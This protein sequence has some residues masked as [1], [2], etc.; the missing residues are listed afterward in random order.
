[1]NTEI[2]LTPTA[3]QF[4]FGQAGR[5]ITGR[6]WGSATE[7]RAA[8]LLVHG[9][10]SHSGWF[11]AFGRRLK[12]KRIYALAYDQLGF[13]KRADQTLIGYQQWLEDVKRVYNHLKEQVGDK[14]IFLMGNSMGAAVAFAAIESVCPDGLVLFSPGF[15]GYPGTF[16]LPFRIKSIIQALFSPQ[17]EIPLPYPIELITREE[18]ARQWIACD[19]DRKDKLPAQM[20]LELLKLT[21]NITAKRVTAPCP[22]LMITAGLDKIVDNKANAEFFAKL[23]SPSK[24]KQHFEHCWHDL[25]FDPEIEHITD[26]VLTWIVKSL[27]EQ[28]P[29]L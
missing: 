1:M 27:P 16:T 29:V 18:S 11:E 21:L 3:S 6:S 4:V 28:M 9:L 14:P 19:P 20:A 5:Q 24:S 25:M 26:T 15:N 8:A 22:V 7:C 17:S 12:V 23:E 2:N 13:G 10:G